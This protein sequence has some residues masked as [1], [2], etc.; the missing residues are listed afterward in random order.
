MN[1]SV[2]AAL[3]VWPGVSPLTG[4]A[5]ADEQADSRASASRETLLR[6]DGLH[7]LFEDAAHLQLPILNR[8]S[9]PPLDQIERILAELL[10]TPAFEN[11]E[12]LADSGGER[13]QVVGPS[14]QP[15]SN[16]GFL[17]AYLQKQLQEI[18]DQRAFF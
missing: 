18:A 1:R 7:C 13:L 6:I 17:G 8:E 12:V 5:G 14:D 11:P 15:R 16:S 10:V 3:Q 9:E 2:P 4:V